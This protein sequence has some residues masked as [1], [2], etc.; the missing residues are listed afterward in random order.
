[1]KNYLLLIIALLVLPILQ[2]QDAEIDFSQLK[3]ITKENAQQLKQ[4]A[5]LGLGEF[6]CLDWSPDGT[7][8]VVGT[9]T[10]LWQYDATDFSHAPRKLSDYND[11]AEDLVFSPDGRQIAFSEG[12]DGI[13]ILDVDSETWFPTTDLRIYESGQFHLTFSPNGRHVASTHSDYGYTPFIWNVAN[14]GPVAYLE[15]HT[16]T[17]QDIAYSPDGSRIVTVSSDDTIHIWDTQSYK[18][19]KVLDD[20]E[21]GSNAVAFTADGQFFIT[22]NYYSMRV[23]NAST[24]ELLQS[25]SLDE[26]SANLSVFPDRSGFVT[27]DG[28]LWNYDESIQK[29][30]SDSDKFSDWISPVDMEIDPSGKYLALG[31]N[32]TVEIYNIQTR[33]LEISLQGYGSE[34]RSIAI[35]DNGEYLASGSRNGALNLWSINQSAGKITHVSTMTEHT[36][37]LDDLVFSPSGE[38]LVSINWDNTLRMWNTADGSLLNTVT[39]EDSIYSMA[40]NDDKSLLAIGMYGTVTVWSIDWIQ[41]QLFDE[42][43]FTVGD[44]RID[45]MFFTPDNEELIVASEFDEHLFYWNL[46]SKELIAESDKKGIWGNHNFL[47]VNHAQNTVIFGSNTSYIQAFSLR[48]NQLMEMW[49][50][51]LDPNLE[52]IKKSTTMHFYVDLTNLRFSPDDSLFTATGRFYSLYVANSDNGE[53][54]TTLNSSSAG[55]DFSLDGKLIAGGSSAGTVILWTVT[56]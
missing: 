52:D 27:A 35:S 49:H 36:S 38:T 10:G 25:E 44:G 42:H 51:S 19:I 34:V 17:V 45:G 4:V 37:W 46:A 5:E 21:N 47:E 7:K 24:G 48:N 54:I 50:N 30:V 18:T 2:A 20:V 13:N 40:V 15:G 14:V 12:I 11:R 23:W 39:V 16:S 26:P 43:T 41:N 56:D 9:R 55:L 3:P 29:F 22:T 32:G 31:T 53:L 33:Q 28:S 6:W 8:L 1:M